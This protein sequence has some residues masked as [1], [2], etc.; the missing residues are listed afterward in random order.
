MKK[1]ISLLILI[2]MVFSLT[3]CN[4]NTGGDNNA[5]K[6]IIVPKLVMNNLYKTMPEFTV[7]EPIDSYTDGTYNYFYFKL[8]EV[9]RVP[10]AYTKS[11]FYQGIGKRTLNFETTNNIQNMLSATAEQCISNT[12]SSSVSTGVNSSLGATDEAAGL[13]ASLSAYIQSTLSSSSTYS[14]SKKLTNSISETFTRREQDIFELDPSSPA[15]VYRYTIYANCEIYAIVI[16][17]LET[18]TFEYT[19]LPFVKEGTLVEG[20]AYSEDGYFETSETIYSDLQK[21]SLDN[22]LS[23]IDLYGHIDKYINVRQGTFNISKS[24]IIAD[25]QYY[26]LRPNFASILNEELL[27]KFGYTKAKINMVCK[28]KTPEGACQTHM[29]ICVG[30][31]ELCRND[32]TRVDT[33]GKTFTLKCEV[34][35]EELKA[36]D[37][38]LRIEFECRSDGILDILKNSFYIENGTITI[39]MQ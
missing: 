1:I 23:G 2:C 9:G 38:T 20:W 26:T 32:F 27:E 39:E 4:I 34:S 15:G 3:A 24:A 5:N 6:P 19:Y 12:V 17:N 35:L 7:N 14:A 28:I 11:V 25:D 31:K 18:M 8:G 22:V 30:D 33:S 36:A 21:F 37:Y 13:S 10:V 29:R 16:A